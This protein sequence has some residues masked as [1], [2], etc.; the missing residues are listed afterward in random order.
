MNL[1]DVHQAELNFTT[2]A[3]SEEYG[4]NYCHN[5]KSFIYAKKKAKIATEL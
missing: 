5:Y 1:N 3:L 2:M 4:W